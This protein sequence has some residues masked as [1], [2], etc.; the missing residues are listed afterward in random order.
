MTSSK[1]IPGD[2]SSGNKIKARDIH[3]MVVDAMLGDNGRLPPFPIKLHRWVDHE[4]HSV[5]Y[6]E[7]NGV[8]RI[9]AKDHVNFL[10]ANYYAQ[11]ALEGENFW[12]QVTASDCEKIRLLWLA[13][14]SSTEGK[15][16]P[17]AFA[18][19]SRLALHKVGF[20]PV[21]GWGYEALF[22]GG[23]PRYADLMKRMTDHK[24]FMAWVGSLF[25][26][27]S[28]RQQYTWIYGSGG[29]GKS[30]LIRA[31]MDQL[32]P[33]A[34]NENPPTPGAKHWTVGLRN[35][36]LVVFADCN[37]ISFVTSGEFKSLTGE[38]GVRIE[39][40]GK[41]SYTEKLQAKYLISS[42]DRP[43]VSSSKAD[44]RRI[45]FF[46][47]GEIEKD[48]GQNYE[49]DL[50]DETELFL[51]FCYNTYLEVTKGNPRHQFVCEQKEEMQE[52]ISN[53]SFEMESFVLGKLIVI[54]DD[55][56]VPMSSKRYIEG[57]KMIEMMDKSGFKTQHQRKVLK[58]YMEREYGLVCRVVKVNGKSIRAFMNCLPS[59]QEIPGYN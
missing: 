35:K 39:Q 13:R 33:V 18:N 9:V 48:F 54:E 26:P 36:R 42:N 37:N 17:L 29:N 2:K 45:L 59:I 19:D 10:I 53:A 24:I 56:Q 27:M 4:G 57:H 34:V 55:P 41:D 38:D 31:I 1:A 32:G 6:E 5:I 43:C 52:V 7:K 23:T 11:C 8:V 40:K 49:D 28:Q 14:S 51:G 20:V 46:K 25:D 58:D 3:A 12:G 30:A 16:I 22:S 50:R 47:I 15:W 21:P 44:M